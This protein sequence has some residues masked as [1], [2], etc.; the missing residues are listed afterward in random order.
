MGFNGE[1]FEYTVGTQGGNIDQKQQ[2]LTEIS[3]ALF[4]PHLFMA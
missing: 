3:S 2:N 4:H 1:T